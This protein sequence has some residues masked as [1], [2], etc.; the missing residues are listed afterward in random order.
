MKA[1]KQV[2]RI[3]F[4]AMVLMLVVVGLALIIIATVLYFDGGTS[5]VWLNGYL[6]M[7]TLL[8]GGVLAWTPRMHRQNVAHAEERMERRRA[9]L[10]AGFQDWAASRG[11]TV[12]EA[13]A[14]S[15]ATAQ[16]QRLQSSLMTRF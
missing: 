12:S 15:V 16:M 4:Q 2:G 11:L 5:D 9:A 7:V 6:G 10:R 8:L 1:I 13:D 14:I 3:L